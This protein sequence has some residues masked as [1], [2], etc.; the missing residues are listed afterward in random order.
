MGWDGSGG[1]GGAGRAAAPPQNLHPSACHILKS[2]G[3]GGLGGVPGHAGASSSPPT[4]LAM[5]NA[6]NL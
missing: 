6:F 1:G 4:T 2:V 5:H 3:G